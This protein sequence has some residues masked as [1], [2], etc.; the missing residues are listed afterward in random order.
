[1]CN[2]LNKCSKLE[3]VSVK[4]VTNNKLNSNIKI[5]QWQVKKNEMS[6]NSS[7]AVKQNKPRYGRETKQ[8]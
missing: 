2:I 1:M 8:W 4:F 7:R 6:V 5:P 3:Y